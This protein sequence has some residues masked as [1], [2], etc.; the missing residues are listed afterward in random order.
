MI[1]EFFMIAVFIAFV[2]LILHS[3]LKYGWRDTLTFFGLAFIFGLIKE[4]IS[5]LVMKRYQDNLTLQILGIPL[6]I[7]FGW[8]YTWYLGRELVRRV[9]PYGENFVFAAAFFATL[10]CVPIETASI[11]AGW[12][13]LNPEGFSI[14]DGICPVQLVIGWWTSAVSFFM[15]Y[16]TIKR[17]IPVEKAV[18]TIVAL[19]MILNGTFLGIWPFLIIPIGFFLILLMRDYKLAIICTYIFILNL[20]LFVLPIVP[21]WSL[22]VT[23]LIVSVTAI[24]ILVRQEQKKLVKQKAISRYL[25][26]KEED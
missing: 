9:M 11:P 7:L 12:W 15:V 18:I 10:I 21:N 1:K 3:Y 14:G 25:P 17:I 22:V 20:I 8:C 5:E 4:V 26:K 16:F 24:I 13:V 2:C 23:S 6:F 19:N